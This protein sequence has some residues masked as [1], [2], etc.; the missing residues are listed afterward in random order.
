MQNNYK[1]R[2]IKTTIV[3]TST[4]TYTKGQSDGI[5]K[6]ISWAYNRNIKTPFVLS[7]FAGTGKTTIARDIV[8]NLK[9]TIACTA[10]THKAVRVV[11]KSIG[12]EGA[13]IQKLLGLRPNIDLENFDINKP[14]FDMLANVAIK[15]YKYILIDECSMINK[16]LY[17]L[18]IRESDNYGVKLLFMGDPYQLPPVGETHSLTFDV[19]NKHN[20]TEIVRQGEDN[21]LITLLTKARDAVKFNNDSLV[22]FLDKHQSSYANDKG[23]ILA[24]DEHFMSL[25]HDKFG[26]NEFETN[27]DY[28]RYTAFTNESVNGMNKYV[29]GHLFGSNNRILIQDD[30]LTSYSTVMDEFNSP[31]IYNSEDYIIHEIFDYTNKFMIK[32]FLVKLKAI[33]GGKIT[34]P[35][36]ILDHSIQDNVERYVDIFYG[37]LGKA[38]TNKNLANRRKAWEKFYEFKNYNLLLS[39]IINNSGYKVVGKDLDY[40][41][42]LT[43]HKTQGSTFQNTFIN[44]NNIIYA[45]SGYPYRDTNL[46][47]RLLYVALSRASDSSFILY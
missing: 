18:L 21:P 3:K 23:Y 36:F 31:I 10:P 42:G 38:K 7:G 37:L 13:T 40:G 25:L 34:R 43:V 11:S 45:K 9:G 44:S 24:D 29:R 1:P 2:T 20:L 19:D 28:C 4:F 6:I 39:D 47:N 17:T 12:K 33:N 35:L 27:I 16:D 46:R 8:K 32:G 5:N 41:F 26:S 22:K 14:Q 15:N 30:L